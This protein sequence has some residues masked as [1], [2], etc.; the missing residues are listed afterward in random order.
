M[1]TTSEDNTH[2]GGDVADTDTSDASSVNLEKDMADMLDGS[3]EPPESE[4][5]IRYPSPD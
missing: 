4:D 3:F 1:A 5:V 2:L